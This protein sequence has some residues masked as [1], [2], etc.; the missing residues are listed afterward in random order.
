MR[1]PDTMTKNKTLDDFM[2]CNLIVQ[3]D[4]LGLTKLNNPLNLSKIEVQ[5]KITIQNRELISLE[6]DL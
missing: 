6:P 1:M 5:K 4:Y 2:C 3:P